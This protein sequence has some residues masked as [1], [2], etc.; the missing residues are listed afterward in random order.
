MAHRGQDRTD[1]LTRF[2]GEL[3]P[4]LAALGLKLAKGKRIELSSVDHTHG[5]VF[6]T[7]YPP[8]DANFHKMAPLTDRSQNYIFKEYCFMPLKLQGC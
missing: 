2:G 3:Q 4:P 7:D 5:T 6:K 8:L 1:Y